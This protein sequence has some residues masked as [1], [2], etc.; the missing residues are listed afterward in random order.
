MKDIYFYK[1]PCIFRYFRRYLLCTW[2]NSWPGHFSDMSSALFITCLR[3]TSVYV[4]SCIWTIPHPKLTIIITLTL[5]L[6]VLSWIR[7]TYVKVSDVLDRISNIV[8]ILYKAISLNVRVNV[9]LYDL[10]EKYDSIFYVVCTIT[11]IACH[12]NHNAN[13]TS[14]IDNLES[15]Y[16][17]DPNISIQSNHG[18]SSH[19][20]W[21]KIN[22]NLCVR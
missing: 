8:V 3:P 15:K 2:T 19:D 9:D 6:T 12:I 21:E 10:W 17:W 5:R 7:L 11:S 13:Y 20:L 1:K 18:N 22:N 14:G 16:N 4:C